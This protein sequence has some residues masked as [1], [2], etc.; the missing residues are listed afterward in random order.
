MNSQP[1]QLETPTDTQI[2]QF[3]QNEGYNNPTHNASFKETLKSYLFTNPEMA[4]LII[5]LLGFVFFPL[6]LLCFMIYFRNNNKSAKV[7]AHVSLVLFILALA[8]PFI[9]IAVLALIVLLIPVGFIAYAAFCFLL[10]LLD[11]IS[12]FTH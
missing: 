11:P 5:F 10:I 4:S 12:P 8:A 3:Q 9:V 7:F 6:W 1:Q 2:G